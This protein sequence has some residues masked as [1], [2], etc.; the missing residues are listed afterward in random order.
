MIIPTGVRS[1]DVKFDFIT[2]DTGGVAL[3]SSDANLAVLD[4][5]TVVLYPYSGSDTRVAHITVTPTV[6][7]P[8]GLAY[9]HLAQD[10]DGRNGAG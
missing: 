6:V 1:I 3:A 9:G 7:L 10:C 4:W 5:N 2:S 8:S